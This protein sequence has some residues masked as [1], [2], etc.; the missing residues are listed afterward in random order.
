MEPH[1]GTY[2]PR[3]FYL[4]DTNLRNIMDCGEYA[5]SVDEM[6]NKRENPT[7]VRDILDHLFSKGKVPRKSFAEQLRRVIKNEKMIL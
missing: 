7:T 5:L 1:S 2:F 6:S 3:S 4:S